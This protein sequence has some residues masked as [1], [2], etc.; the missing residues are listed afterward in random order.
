MDILEEAV[1]IAKKKSHDS[2][3]WK[4]ILV[5]GLVA[6]GF[7]IFFKFIGKLAPRTNRQHIRDLYIPRYPSRR[8]W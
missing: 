8:R 4:T 5:I 6:L 2:N 7:W 3:A 1:K